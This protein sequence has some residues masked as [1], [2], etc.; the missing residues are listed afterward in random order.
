MQ[1][2]RN[3]LNVCE[4]KEIRLQNRKYTWSNERCHSTLIRL[5]RFFC[6]QSWD[7]AFEDHALHALSS[8]HSD[9][10]PLLLN[11]QTGPRRAAP[12]RFENIW[13]RLPRFNET[14]ATAWNEPTHHT[15]PFHRLGHKL[16]QTARA[17]KT[18][19]KSLISD[20]RMKLHMAQEVMERALH[21][22]LKRRLLGRA[23]LEPRKIENSRKLNSSFVPN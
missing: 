3:T 7:L 4:L 1:S 11:S 9:H 16:H 14:I 21:T 19:S 18:W 17:L 22:K 23:V 5:D 6:N 15:E 2:F 13:T 8:S 12:F 20:A 10:C